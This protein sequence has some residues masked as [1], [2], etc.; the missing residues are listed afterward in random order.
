MTSEH[1]PLIQLIVTILTFINALGMF[2]AGVI[3]SMI[4]SQ[5]K[6]IEERS[7]RNQERIS[8]FAENYVTKADL[9][10]AEERIQT[11][12][13]EIKDVIRNGFSHPQKRRK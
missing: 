2:F 4:R 9:R 7:N 6:G 13:T 8:Q 3:I 12:I 11:A 10:D 5:M 1:L